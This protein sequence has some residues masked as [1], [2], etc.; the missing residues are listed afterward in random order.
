MTAEQKAARYASKRYK[1]QQPEWAI[2]RQA[3]IDGHKDGYIKGSNDCD[4]ITKKHYNLTPKS[5]VS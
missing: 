5:D 3:Y 4:E 2:V 1:P